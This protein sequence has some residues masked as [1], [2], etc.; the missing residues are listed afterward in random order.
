MDKIK[1]T[2]GR[3]LNGEVRISGAKNAALPLIASSILVNGTLSFSN[4]PNLMDI[5]SIRL[6]LEDLGARCHS[7]SGRLE[8]DASTIHNIEAE[9]DLVRKM[10]ASVLVLGPL[11]AR[12]GHAKVSLPGG[13]AIGA[14]PVNMHLAGLEALGADIS[15]DHGYIEAK[16]TRLTGN[17]IYFDIPT[18]TGTENLMMAAVLAQGTTTLRNAAREPE[19]VA[20]ADALNKM[21]AKI[22][23]AGTA[24]IT[25]D[26]VDQ[27][28]PVDITIIPDRIE[29]GTFMVAAAA[30]GGDVMINDCNPDHIGGIISKLRASGAV[31]ETFENSLRVQGR[32]VIKSVDIKT[33]PYPGFPTDM[34]AQFMSL[35]TIADGNSVIHESIFENRFVHANELLRMGADISISGGNYAAVRGIKNLQGAEVM[36]SDLR[37]SASLVIAG[38]IAEGTTTISRVYHMDRGYEAIEEKFSRLGADIK[39]I[40]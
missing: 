16:A 37:A 15:I 19:I 14:R 35:M 27:L 25:I 28:N 38:L 13:C 17:E 4:V 33:L 8:I 31:V 3:Q 11:V 23:G 2:G 36:A 1:I 12:F 30:T 24:I 20:L 9:Y 40:K 6:L 21:G 32:P 34:Q 29:T 5:L 22:T 10:R 26:G 18:V 7:E 39:R